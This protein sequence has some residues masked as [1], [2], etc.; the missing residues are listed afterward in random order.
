MFNTGSA[1]YLEKSS[2]SGA[3]IVARK[4]LFTFESL[5]QHD[6][7]ARHAARNR[8]TFPV[9][10]PG[11]GA[12]LAFT[13]SLGQLARRRAVDRLPPE[14]GV[15]LAVV[16][17]VRLSIRHPTRAPSGNHGNRFTSRTRRQIAHGP[18]TVLGNDK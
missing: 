10:G 18:L 2:L 12:D 6:V 15:R 13:R 4:G 3:R 5:E 7:A 9:A 17:A 14:D 16:I 11:V 1:H 8:E